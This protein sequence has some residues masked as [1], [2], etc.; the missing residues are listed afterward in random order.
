[1]GW[2][3]LERLAP[4]H[5]DFV[6]GLASVREV[7]RQLYTDGLIG[8]QGDV[9]SITEAGHSEAE[10]LRRSRCLNSATVHVSF[11]PSKFARLPRRRFAGLARIA[12]GDPLPVGVTFL[13]ELSATG[14][15]IAMAAYLAPGLPFEL[16][17]VGTT[18]TWVSSN[19][20]IGRARVV[21]APR[22]QGRNDG[23]G[24]NAPLDVAITEREFI[25]KPAEAGSPLR[26]AA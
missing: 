19:V 11:D 20:V 18:I 13:D 3:E 10:R 16:L 8:D 14:E 23:F 21:C 25:D 5:P 12:D 17:D 24:D 7:S 2:Y 15:G 4:L 1:M 9:W 22:L 6:V 26:K